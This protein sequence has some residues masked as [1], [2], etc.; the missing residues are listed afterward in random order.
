MSPGAKFFRT[1]SAAMVGVMGA[2]LLVNW[3]TEYKVGLIQLALGTLT[4]A[5]AGVAAYFLALSGRQADSPA[6][7]ALNTF[8]QI[9]AG[10]IAPVIIAEVAD[11]V[12][13][14]RIL[15]PVVVGAVVGAAQTFFQTSLEPPTP[16]APST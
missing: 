7:K 6:M 8:W 16:P 10:G 15:V 14:P 3:T 1:F 4:A 11:L 9:L 5:L 13:L 2:A 12:T